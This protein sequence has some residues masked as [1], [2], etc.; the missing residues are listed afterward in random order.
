[1]GAH[2]LNLEFL[3]ACRVKRSRPRIDPPRPPPDE[4]I[5]EGQKRNDERES[6]SRSFDR[7]QVREGGGEEAHAVREVRHRSKPRKCPTTTLKSRRKTFEPAAISERVQQLLFMHAVS[8]DAG[9]HPCHRLTGG[10]LILT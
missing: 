1:M 3:W 10:L 9:T 6:R 2:H 7:C 8:A 4:R 5:T